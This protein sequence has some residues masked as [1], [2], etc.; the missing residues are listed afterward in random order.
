MQI[1]D[2]TLYGPPADA[3]GVQSDHTLLATLRNRYGDSW[4]PAI[5]AAQALPTQLKLTNEKSERAFWK[6]M[7]VTQISL[8]DAYTVRQVN[9]STTEIWLTPGNVRTLSGR[10]DRA[11]TLKFTVTDEKKEEE[12][13]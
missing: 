9:V 7:V 12:L 11:T 5:Q 13:T 3:R 1:R 6:Q 2:S 4:T 10:D 8:R